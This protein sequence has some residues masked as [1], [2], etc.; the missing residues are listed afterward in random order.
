MHHDQVYF[1]FFTGLTLETAI[2][3]CSSADIESWSSLDEHMSELRAEGRLP[4]ASEVQE[5]PE[6]AA[7]TLIETD[8]RYL[9][10][11]RADYL[12]DPGYM[13]FLNNFKQEIVD[14]AIADFNQRFPNASL[15]PESGI[16]LNNAGETLGLFSEKLNRIGRLLAMYRL[17]INQTDRPGLLDLYFVRATTDLLS[18]QTAD[19]AGLQS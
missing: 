9:H 12:I 17:S 6:P 7:D 4:T 11:A 16:F 5:M 8:L 18:E 1:D 3:I 2:A 15:K 13:R 19:N 10:G 14:T